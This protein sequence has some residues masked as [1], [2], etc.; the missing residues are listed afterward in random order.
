MPDIQSNIPLNIFHSAI[1]A[2]FL[3]TV[4]SPV[5][6]RDFIPKTKEVLDIKEV[7]MT[8]IYNIYIYIYICI[9]ILYY[10]I[11]YYYDI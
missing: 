5:C 9:C 4:H 7:Y 6:L 3:R 11:Y 8:Y 10:Y 1:K 2:E